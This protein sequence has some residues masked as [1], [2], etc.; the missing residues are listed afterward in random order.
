MGI[1]DRLKPKFASVVVEEG[2]IGRAEVVLRQVVPSHQVE[3]AAL[4]TYGR[5]GGTW[6]FQCQEHGMAMLKNN[7]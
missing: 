4:R 5:G 2:G 1:Q 7:Q 6:W 3:A